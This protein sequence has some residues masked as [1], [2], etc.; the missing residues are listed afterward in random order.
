MTETEP[1]AQ[2]AIRAVLRAFLAAHDGR[3]MPYDH[4]W[5]WLHER[6]QHELPHAYISGFHQLGH[7]LG[8]GTKAAEAVIAMV[9]EEHDAWHGLAP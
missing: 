7:Q 9:C 5:R 3:M 2:R 8:G 1:S 6:D 4:F